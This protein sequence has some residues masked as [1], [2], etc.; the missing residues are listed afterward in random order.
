MDCPCERDLAPDARR[1]LGHEAL[2]V[3][4]RQ[5]V[6]ALTDQEGPAARLPSPGEEHGPALADVAPQVRDEG[7]R[8]RETLP[9]PVLDPAR[10]QAVLREVEVEQPSSTDLGGAQA[11]P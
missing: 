3:L 11:E 10:E 4:G 6:A 2:E 7:R 1:D 9:R 5:R 8:Q